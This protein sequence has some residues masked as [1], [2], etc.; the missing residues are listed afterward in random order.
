MALSIKQEKFP[1]P[2]G[3]LTVF[4]PVQVD[5]VRYALS[6]GEAILL[7]IKELSEVAEKEGVTLTG[8]P[9]FRSVTLPVTG[10]RFLLGEQDY[11]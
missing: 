10:D 5:G 2:D 7:G 3:P 4:V 6:H 1:E 8:K 11:V 9:V